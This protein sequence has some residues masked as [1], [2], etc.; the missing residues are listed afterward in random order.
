MSSER[1]EQRA[2]HDGQREK[3]RKTH[4]PI[5]VDGLASLNLEFDDMTEK[6]YK[7][8]GF[9]SKAQFTVTASAK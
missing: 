2:G 3:V 5:I 7:Q 8:T 9:G 4:D 6:L 1:D